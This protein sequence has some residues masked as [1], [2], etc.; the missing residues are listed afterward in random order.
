V[1]GSEMGF[2]INDIRFR[3]KVWGLEFK[4]YSQQFKIRVLGLRVQGKWFRV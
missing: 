3:F 4:V 1:S 2:R